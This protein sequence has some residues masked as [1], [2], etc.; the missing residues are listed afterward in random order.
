MHGLPNEFDFADDKI[1]NKDTTLEIQDIDN[2]YVH[3]V[4][5]SFKHYVSSMNKGDLLTIDDK[6]YQILYKQFFTNT[7]KVWVRIDGK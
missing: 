7:V 3:G 6:A 2:G 1:D 5:P 4:P